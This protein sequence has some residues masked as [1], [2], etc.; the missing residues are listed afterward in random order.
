MSNYIEK[1]KT[2]TGAAWPVRDTE[3]HASLNRLAAQLTDAE[4]A[5]AHRAGLGYGLGELVT[6]TLEE[7]HSMCTERRSV[8]G[9]YVVYDSITIDGHTFTNGGVR[10]DAVQEYGSVWTY[11]P[12]HEPMVELKLYNPYDAI[13]DRWEWVNPPMEVGHVYRTTERIGGKPVYRAAIDLGNITT[14]TDG[15]FNEWRFTDDISPQPTDLIE[16]ILI[17]GNGANLA[18]HS[19]VERIIADTS[20][21]KVKN[22]ANINGVTAYLR[23]TAPDDSDL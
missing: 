17:D 14:K 8:S 5:I 9:W 3:A 20:V 18:Y 1:I 23:Y 6:K 13:G 12:E 11:Y 15:T 2:G 22:T 4:I 10:V 7:L 19:D 21:I 16:V